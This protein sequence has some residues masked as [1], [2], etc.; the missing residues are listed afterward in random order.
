MQFRSVLVT[1][2]ALSALAS[3]SAPAADKSV[4]AGPVG[5]SINNS[6]RVGL[7]TATNIDY[8][9]RSIADGRRNVALRLAQPMLCADFATPPGG[10]VNPVSL[11]YVDTNLD[12]FGPLYGGITSFDYFTN[13]AAAGLFKVS[14]GG[15]LACC[16]MSPAANASCFQGVNGGAVAEA[17]FAS[18]FE[19]VSALQPEGSTPANLSV[20]VSGPTSATPGANFDYTIVVTNIGGTSVSGVQV[21]DWYPKL[22]G[23]FPA[24]LATGSWSCA[25]SGGA[26]CGTAAGTGNI[27]LTAVSLPAGASISFSVSRQLNAGSTLGAQ[28]SVSAAAFAPPSA[29]ET[30]LGNNQGVLSAGVQQASFSIN[31]VTQAEGTGGNTTFQFTITRSNTNTAASVVVNTADG[32]ATAGSDYTAISNQTVNFTAGGSAT[33]TV[34]VT[35]IGDAVLEGNET[36]T[37]NLSNPSGAGI[38]DGTG[39]GTITNDD[40]A[41]LS[42]NDVTLSEGNS[43]S[44]NATFTVTLNAAVQGGFTVPVSSSNGSATAGSDYTAIPGGTTLSFTG[45]AGETRTISVPVL[46]DTVLE[47]NETFNVTLGTPSNA[48]VT[49][50]D[51]TGVGTINNDDAAALSINDVSVS[52]GNSGTTN[53]TFT[54]TLDAAVQGGFTVPVSSANGSATS[55][56]DY[57]AIPGGTTL[58]FTGTAGE[59]RTISVAV[60]GD[61]TLEANETFTVNLGTPSNAA[62]TLADSSGTGT[63]NNDDNASIA[64]NDVSVAEG[65]AGSTNAT[66]T[67]TLSGSVQGGFTVPVSSQSGTATA[68]SDYT[69]L[70]GGSTL[71]FAGTAGETQTVTVVVI[72]DTML[73]PNEDFFVN[74]GV[75]SNGAITRTDSQGIGTITNDDTASLSINDVSVTEGNTGTV[76]ATF[77]ISLAGSVQGSFS[78][79]VSSSDDTATVANNDYVAIAPATTVIFTGATNETRTISVVVNGDTTVEPNEFF[80]VNLGAPNNGQVTVSDAQG[81]G[82]ITNDDIPSG[83]DK[84]R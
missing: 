42:I 72:G 45:T 60:I 78:V 30:V 44:T 6:G 19:G 17:V 58:S 73:E 20:T 7:A 12:A 66:F 13:G 38:T 63:I 35:V 82:T 2:I 33:A 54:V 55:G 8:L 22:A 48:A 79:P 59:T 74:L 46:G 61:T 68:G 84:R 31:D 36:F 21:R 34:S 28:F 57:T 70:P 16:V 77:T 69:S 67:V 83:A 4:T 64:I 29:G 80:Q 15:D 14:A 39:Q 26:S 51:A 53:A 49:L 40:A 18:G 9:N 75:P 52:E 25:A 10:A 41:A 71:N 1:A 32:S 3:G 27:A 43:G 47:P 23:G 50:A 76:N 24:P 56:S 11:T 65:N 37:V 62:V 81:I 5:L